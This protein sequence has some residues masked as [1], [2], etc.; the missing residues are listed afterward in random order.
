MSNSFCDENMSPEYQKIIDLFYNFILSNYNLI[1]LHSFMNCFLYIIIVGGNS[2]A[3]NWVVNC[4][5]CETVNPIILYFSI[6]LGSHLYISYLH[7]LQLSQLILNYIVCKWFFFWIWY[8]CMLLLF[9]GP[10]D[11]YFDFKILNNII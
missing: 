5:M 6:C 8:I 4:L 2:S 1:Y 7:H 9:R 3:N 11:I 10:F